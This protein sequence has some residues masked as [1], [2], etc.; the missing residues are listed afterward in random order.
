[1]TFAVNT[2]QIGFQTKAGTSA[3]IGFVTLKGP[4]AV[5]NASD[6]IALGAC[7]SGS[8]TNVTRGVLNIFGGT[9]GAS[10]ITA[11]A[12]SGGNTVA[13]N[14]GTLILTNAA[15]TPDLPIDSVALT[16]ASLQL[17][18]TPGMTNIVAS[19]LV[20]GGSLNAVH[21]LSLDGVSG[22]GQFPLIKYAGTIGG[23]GFNFMLETLPP[24]GF[25]NAYL[26]NNVANSSVDLV[27]TEL[28]AEPPSPV[29]TNFALSG[30]NLIFGGTNGLR[31]GVY[32]LRASRDLTL[33]ADE[34]PVVGTNVFDG[35]GGFNVTNPIEPSGNQLFYLLQL[36]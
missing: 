35:N 22:P 6:V 23:A 27:V 30:T 4:N 25:I 12:G 8:A 28:A 19:T 15:G 2:L 7:G 1:G 20:T 32:W 18:V 9:V 16:N 10:A 5:L 31:N 11:G 13:M 36:Q 29:I 26:S 21:I 34:W 17:Y 24:D 3:G 14:G 33:P